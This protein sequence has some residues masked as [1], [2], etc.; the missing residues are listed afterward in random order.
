MRKHCPQ[1][2]TFV[3]YVVMHGFHGNPKSDSQ[4]WECI[5]KINHI[6]TATS[7]R[8]LNMLRNKSLDIDLL[9]VCY[10]FELS[11]LHSLKIFMK[12]LKLRETHKNIHI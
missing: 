3:Y 1:K 11:N 4:E 2:S 6:S 12:T 9:S 10:T 5:Y 8:P 7:P